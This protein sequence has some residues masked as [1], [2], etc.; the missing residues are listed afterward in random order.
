MRGPRFRI[1]TFMIVVVLVALY[2]GG[3]LYGP[4]RIKLACAVLVVCFPVVAPLVYFG[5]K[6]GPNTLFR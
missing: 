3:L 6:L 4:P 2:L 5:Y 1:R